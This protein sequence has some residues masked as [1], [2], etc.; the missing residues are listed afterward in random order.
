ML[1]ATVLFALVTVS[2]AS[3]GKMT[4]FMKKTCYLLPK[5]KSSFEGTILDRQ[6]IYSLFLLMYLIVG[7]RFSFKTLLK[8]MGGKYPS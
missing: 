6:K 3:E 1:S 8:T 2:V 4:C 7:S 5:F